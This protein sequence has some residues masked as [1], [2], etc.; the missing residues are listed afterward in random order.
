MAEIGVGI[1]YPVGFDGL[2]AVFPTWAA[3]GD[4][5]CRIP[6][7]SGAYSAKL[8]RETRVDAGTTVIAGEKKISFMVARQLAKRAANHSAQWRAYRHKMMSGL[9]VVLRLGEGNSSI[10]DYLV[11]PTSQ[12]T[13]E[14]LRFSGSSIRGATCVGTAADLILEIRTRFAARSKRAPAP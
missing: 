10:F 3:P 5:R 11:L 7:D 9:L 8:L 1:E 2:A 6:V 14:Y 12:I 13:G 4:V